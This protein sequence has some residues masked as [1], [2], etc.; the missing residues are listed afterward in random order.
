[1]KTRLCSR[2][3]AAPLAV[4]LTLGLTG[5]D[6]DSSS[7]GGGPG[8]C[9]DGFTFED[10]S[11]VQYGSLTIDRDQNTNPAG[12]DLEKTLF[13]KFARIAKPAVDTK[14]KT[15]NETKAKNAYDFFKKET[16]KFIGFN[17]DNLPDYH[18]VKNGF[19]LLEAMI[20]SGN[21]APL[22]TARDAMANCVR[23]EAP[24]SIRVNTLNVTETEPPEEDR[25]TWELGVNYAHNPEPLT[26]PTPF[27][28]NVARVAFTPES[29]VFTLYPSEAFEGIGPSSGFKQPRKLIAGFNA[30]FEETVNEEESSGDSE[31]DEG[32]PDSVIFESF[33]DN[34]Q[35]DRGEDRSQT[36][37]WSW[38]S[39]EGTEAFGITARCIRITAFYAKDGDDNQISVEADSQTCPGIS[40]A[41]TLEDPE[42]SFSY[43]SADPAVEQVRN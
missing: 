9:T 35:D 8:S 7:S 17:K 25:E 30:D 32:D 14:N 2:A 27:G 13:R 22:Q 40:S 1:M 39:E 21:V 24:G 10:P 20:A 5:C 33:L 38:S 37:R 4:L 36:D 23:E 28:P 18:Q 34:T 15:K 16:E 26:D 19:D 12:A 29:F 42:K 43:K 6:L 41:S 31:N 11:E 3:Y